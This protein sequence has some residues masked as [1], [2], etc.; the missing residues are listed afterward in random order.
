ML[1]LWEATV[2]VF[3]EETADGRA[4]ARTNSAVAEVLP[5]TISIFHGEETC[6]WYLVKPPARYSHL[7]SPGMTP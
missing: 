4:K 5:K 1:M 2:F 6:A 3:L 7:Y